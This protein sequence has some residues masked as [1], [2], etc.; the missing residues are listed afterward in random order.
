MAA[1][2]VAI[3]TSLGGF[4]ALKTLLGALPKDF[5]LPVG[6][7]QHRSCEDSEAFAPLLAGQT[8]LPVIEVDDKMEIK[9]GY[10]YV[11]PS[12]YHMLV[13]GRHFALS[14]DAPVLHARPS[15]DVFFE[16]VGQ[17]FREGAVGVLLTGMS[18]DG[19]I[20]LARIKEC[21]GVV[22]VQ[23]PAAA[24]GRIMPEAAIASVEVDKILLLEEIAPFLKTLCCTV[25]ALGE[26]PA[27]QRAASRDDG[28][29]P[30]SASATARSLKNRPPGRF[31]V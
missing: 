28:P 13:D 31:E 26:A 16:S 6:V 29:G 23:N 15:I 3:G 5:P 14:T 22:V 24:E 30:R 10:V 12:N 9:E 17:T 18:Q 11:C 19:T 21:G 27:R 20:G 8:K 25:G 7:I 4:Q 1:Q 2:F